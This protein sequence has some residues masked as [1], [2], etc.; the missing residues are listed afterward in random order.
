MPADRRLRIV[1]SIG[2]R[3][4]IILFILI[5]VPWNALF[6]P[7]YWRRV[8]IWSKITKVLFRDYRL[9]MIKR[10]RKCLINL[11]TPTIKNFASKVC[12][13]WVSLDPKRCQNRKKS[14]TCLHFDPVYLKSPSNICRTALLMSLLEINFGSSKRKKRSPS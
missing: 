4:G 13:N 2:W 11:S 5:R 8:R 12:K 10:M 6:I 3:I 7:R 1:R 14:K 9:I